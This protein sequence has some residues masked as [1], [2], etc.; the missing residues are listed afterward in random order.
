MKIG[1]AHFCSG[2]RPRIGVRGV[3]SPESPMALWRPRKGM[4][5]VGRRMVQTGR[6]ARR[7]LSWGQAPALRFSRWT[8]SVVSRL[9]FFLAATVRGFP[10][11]RDEETR[12]RNDESGGW[13]RS[14]SPW[15]LHE[16]MYGSVDERSPQGS[17]SLGSNVGG[18]TITIRSLTHSIE[19]RN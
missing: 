16:T 10:P 18:N 3:L 9:S 14:K 11:P 12:G 15:K 6:A 7:A 17:I 19:A 5:M 4:K 8:Q 1:A 2:F 13:W